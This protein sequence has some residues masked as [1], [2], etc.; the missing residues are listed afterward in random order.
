[1]A[2]YNITLSEEDIKKLADDIARSPVERFGSK[3]EFCRYWPSAKNVLEALESILV[4]VPGV[5]TMAIL[6]IK[7]AKAVG[8]SAQAALC[9]K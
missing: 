2:Q 3:E 9:K 8:D 1:M 5:G 7:A 6:A 4:V